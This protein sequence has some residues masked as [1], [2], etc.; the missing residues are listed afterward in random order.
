MNRCVNCSIVALDAFLCTN[1]TAVL[2]ADLTSA[3]WL[4]N[5]LDVTLTRQ[6]RTA[7]PNV[8]YVHTGSDETPLPF[9]ERASIA[10]ALLRNTLSTWARDATE[11]R[12]LVYDGDTTTAGIAR[13][14]RGN[15][16][17]LRQSATVGELMDGVASVVRDSVRAI[18]ARAM[19][20][21]QG[22]CH[23]PTA[24][25][26]CQAELWSHRSEPIILCVE[27]GASHTWTGRQ[28]WLDAIIENRLLTAAEL[29][30]AIYLRRGI[31]LQEKRIHEWAYRN[32]LRVRGK[33]FDRR[34]L[35]RAGDAF[36]LIRKQERAS[37]RR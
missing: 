7:A 3:E 33:T 6:S 1:C 30:D 19:K 17:S 20:I 35:Y 21:F 12:G 32:R 8:G 29:I 14:L 15:V 24:F 2:R 27:C 28:Q 4:A 31:M 26:K 9:D 25:G 22:P 16:D 23:A 11:S 18:D 10:A 5:E 34:P 13:W 37:G 36:K